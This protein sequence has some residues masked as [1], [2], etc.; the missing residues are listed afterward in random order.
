MDILKQL[1]DHARSR[2]IEKKRNIPE[3]EMKNLALQITLPKKDS[4]RTALEHTG[5]SFICECKKASPSKGIIDSEFAY[6]EIAEDY[7]AAGAD[8]ISCLTEPRYFLGDD[9]YLKEI[10]VLPVPVLRK[11]F[12]V[13]PYMIYEARTLGASAVL[14]IVAILQREELQEYLEVAHS[15]GLHALVEVHDEEEAA[16]AVSC[17]AEIIGVNNRNLR[18][19][20]VDI[21]NSIRLRDRIPGN[22][23]MVAESGIRSR[24]DIIRMENAGISGVLIGET[25]MKAKDRKKMLKELKGE[26]TI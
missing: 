15:I 10:S 3:E 14:L 6:R 24:E 1:S 19:F 13:D 8:A 12:I 11:D 17:G 20:S 18:D 5:M 23:L 4:F 7:V 2:V 22:I 25:L 21:N 26:M 9:R 16:A